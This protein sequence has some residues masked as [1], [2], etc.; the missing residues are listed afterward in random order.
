MGLERMVGC[1][2]NAVLVEEGVLPHVVCGRRVLDKRGE[3]GKTLQTTST[4][5]PSRERD[6]FKHV[7]H[8]R[9]IKIIQDLAEILGNLHHYFP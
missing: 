2:L 8:K 3:E 4:T 1:K 6:R 9:E 5:S 7:G